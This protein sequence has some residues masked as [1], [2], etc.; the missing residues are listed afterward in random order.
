MAGSRPT[1]RTTEFLRE[2][3]FAYAIVEKFVRFPPPGHLVDAFGCI[4][5]IAVGCR[6]TLAIQTCR[7]E[8]IAHRLGKVVAAPALPKMLESGWDVI[9]IG[10]AK[11]GPR[12]KAKRWTMTAVRVEGS[13]LQYY[14]RE[15]LSPRLSI[16]SQDLVKPHGKEQ[17]AEIPIEQGGAG[18]TG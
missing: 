14:V 18:C 13:P 4:D 9:I 16:T 1:Q 5:I 8:D 2:L 7:T 17:K 11:R 6:R 10:W 15:I 3:G 12:G